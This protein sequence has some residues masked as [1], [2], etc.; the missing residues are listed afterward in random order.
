MHSA[1]ALP[2]LLVSRPMVPLS[3]RLA[4]VGKAVVLRDYLS[5]LRAAATPPRVLE[6][7]S[8]YAALRAAEHARRRVPAYQATLVRAGWR[9]A[10]WLPAHERLRRYQETDKA[11]YIKAYTTEE[12]CLDG[13]IPM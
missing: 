6:A 9:D 4:D 1:G 3:L 13:T 5:F 10:P 2:R 12:R 8:P 7:L 11:S